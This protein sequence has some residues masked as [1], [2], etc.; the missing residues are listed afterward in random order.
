[1]SMIAKKRMPRFAVRRLWLEFRHRVSRWVPL[2]EAVDGLGVLVIGME[3]A[4]SDLGRTGLHDLGHLPVMVMEP[5]TLLW[6]SATNRRGFLHE[7]LA[8]HPTVEAWTVRRLLLETNENAA[9]SLPDV[10]CSMV[11]SAARI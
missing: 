10:V 9:H 11:G 8:I 1:M 6:G 3:M 2:L 7:L 5:V 4:L